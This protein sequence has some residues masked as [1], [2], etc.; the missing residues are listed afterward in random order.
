[1]KFKFVVKKSIFA[2]S[3]AG[4]FLAL[5]WFYYLSPRPENIRF[6]N[7]DLS[8]TDYSHSTISRH[9]TEGLYWLSFSTSSRWFNLNR[10]RLRT[11]GCMNSLSTSRGDWTLPS[12]DDQRCN[13]HNGFLL[14]NTSSFLAK[15]T[16]WF[17]AGST[18]PWNDYGITME[19]D[20]SEW[21][22]VGGMIFLL[23]SLIIALRSKL[24]LQDIK[25]RWIVAGLLCG[26]FLLRFWFVFIV[27][28]IETTLFSDMMAYFNRGWEI[29]HGIY[30]LNQIFQPI[31]F[32]LWSLFIRKLG[33]FEL[34]GWTQ[35]FFS[36]GIVLL[37]F[38]MVRQRFGKIAGL[39]SLIIASIHIPQAGFAAMHLSENIYGF[40]ITWTL[41]LLLKT[42]KSEKLSSFFVVGLLLSLAFYFKGNHSFFIP[43]LACW[44]IFRERPHFSK[45]IAKVSVLV[46]GCLTVTI[47]HLFWTNAH[48]GKPYFGPLA[49]ALNFVE[50]KCPSKENQDSEGFRWMSP[51]FNVTGE[52]EFK[53]WPRPFTDQSYFWKEGFKCVQENP[54]ILVTSIRYIYYLFLGND[55][56]PVVYTPLKNWYTPWSYFYNYAVL[57]L[58]LLGALVILRKREPCDQ[59]FILMILT[60]FFTVWFFKSENRFRVPF[61]AILIIW[62]SVGFAWLMEGIKS[63]VLTSKQVPKSPKVVALPE[64]G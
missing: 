22:V 36:W 59:P 9:N 18:T 3:L 35:V 55:L 17:I 19:K 42:L 21:P 6:I 62:S 32:T 60:L 43:A 15:N 48:L 1:M 20:W 44:L 54:W 38:L 25:E 31:G 57:P 33:G 50:G 40:L 64:E 52:K 28:P 58:C 29:D 12:G 14:K 34:L 47:P 45:G 5:W 8:T 2:L 37:I 16:E 30:N 39:A 24:P 10:L 13:N 41:W 4:I 23:T 53:Q 63:I 46:I 7:P 26:A 27:S 51:L 49:G 61:D 11:Y 56:W